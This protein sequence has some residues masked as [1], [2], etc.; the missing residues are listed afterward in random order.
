M[1]LIIVSGPKSGIIIFLDFVPG[2]KPEMIR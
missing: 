1:A 2:T